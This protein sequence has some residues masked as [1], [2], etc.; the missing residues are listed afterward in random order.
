MKIKLTFS[1]VLAG[2]A[3]FL[4]ACS[5][6]SSD[7][8]T[9]YKGETVQHIYDK[10]KKALKSK[11]YNEAVKRFE[12]LDAQYPFNTYTEKG[13]LYLIYAYYMKDE[14]ILAVSAADHYIR[15]YPTS[16][17]VDYAYYMR[18]L[19]NFYLNLGVFE[20]HFTLDLS[21]RD[22]AQIK[23]SFAD[24][25]ELILQFPNSHY[26]SDARQ[27]LVYL[28]NIIAKHE[29]NVADFYFKRKAYVAAI[30]RANV[31]V[32]QFQESPSVVPALRIMVNAYGILG[33]TK[34][35]DDTLAILQANG[36][37]M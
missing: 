6:N 37:Q 32:T 34:Q 9:L 23:K 31:V 18:G 36:Y 20:R 35:H 8:A 4:S 1:V 14:Y 17:H 10:G 11:N 3:T 28:R 26:A 24:F 16:S 2:L 29:L 15:V 27:H 12:A 25:N 22:L 19:A 13:D 5:T 30:N 33:L 7:V 21:E